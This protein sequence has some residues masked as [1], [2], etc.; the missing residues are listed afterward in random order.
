MVGDQWFLVLGVFVNR[1]NLNVIYIF[2]FSIGQKVMNNLFGRPNSKFEMFEPKNGILISKDVEKNISL[3][4]MAIEPNISAR[5]SNCLGLIARRPRN[6]G[7]STRERGKSQ[8]DRQA[9]VLV[10]EMR[11]HFCE[12][13]ARN[14]VDY[15]CYTTQRMPFLLKT[16]QAAA[17]C[18]QRAIAKVIFLHVENC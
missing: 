5:P 1:R 7:R 6:S 17:I 9:R 14:Y 2:P 11:M 16:R 18:D 15:L 12:I 10:D 4:F 8:A 3:G 13:S